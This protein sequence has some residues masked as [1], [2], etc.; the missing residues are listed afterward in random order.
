MSIR[1]ISIDCSL[2]LI[3]LPFSKRP[4]SLWLLYFLL[5]ILIAA[6]LP[7]LLGRLVQINAEVQVR[8]CSTICHVGVRTQKPYQHQFQDYHEVSVAAGVSQADIDQAQALL[9]A[10]N[11]SYTA[12]SLVHFDVYLFT[13]LSTGH[14]FNMD[15][16]SFPDARQPP[17]NSFFCVV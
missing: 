2:L 1:F 15:H 16:S 11:V 9:P 7:F 10:F 5:N 12:T 14:F 13:I 4:W 17:S 8:V 6:M 3:L